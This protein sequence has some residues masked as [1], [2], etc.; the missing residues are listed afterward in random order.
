[1]ATQKFEL[2]VLNLVR[3]CRDRR[4]D[5]TAAVPVRDVEKILLDPDLDAEQ[6]LARI[7]EA[8]VEAPF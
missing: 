2:R 7:V 1:M 3:A 6:M 5:L 4:E 8:I